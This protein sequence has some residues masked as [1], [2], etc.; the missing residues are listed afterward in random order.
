MCSFINM[1]L[2]INH[3]ISVIKINLTLAFNF[4]LRHMVCYDFY[5]MKYMLNNST[6]KAYNEY[7]DISKYTLLYIAV[8]GP[9]INTHHFKYIFSCRYLSIGTNDIKSHQIIDL[10]NLTSSK[11]MPFGLIVPK[12][13]NPV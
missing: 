6:I 7:G 12:F 8:Y 11:P 10:D 9:D 5:M 4:L 1:I 2:V 3:M 13:Y